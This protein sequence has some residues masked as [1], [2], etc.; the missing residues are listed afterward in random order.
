[1]PDDIQEITLRPTRVS[2]AS[3][4]NQPGPANF[5]AGTEATL[6]PV[7]ITQNMP[8]QILEQQAATEA[9]YKEMAAP[10][11]PPPA[12]P[13]LSTEAAPLSPPQ[14]VPPPAEPP[15][16]ALTPG[17]TPPPGPVEPAPQISE[18]EHR[19]RS[20][21]G[22]ARAATI[23][24]EAAEA[25]LADLT[26]RLTRL[27]NQR[28]QPVADGPLPDLTPEE[29]ETMGPEIVAMVN[30]RAAIIARGETERLRGEIEALRAGQQ[31]IQKSAQVSARDNMLAEL[32]RVIPNWQTTNTDDKFI[33]WLSQYDRLR[34]K[35]R[36]DMLLD[37]YNQNDAERVIA[38]FQEYGNA[39]GVPAQGA[40]TPQPGAV[41]PAPNKLP[42][43]S[44]AA[45]ARGA[46]SAAPSETEKHIW[47]PALVTAFYRDVQNGR[48][49][50]K[51]PERLM[52]EA[53]LINAQREGRYKEK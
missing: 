13:P 33:N 10:P 12:D 3:T 22:R 28:G 20:E 15:P 5:A 21:Q 43:E 11:A 51:E 49:A 7:K 23:R 32:N 37:A 27:E 42:L 18:W 19:Y 39:S 14:P 52:W 41:P 53:D 38:F 8:R 46:S 26:T 36:Q 45:P 25:Q 4:P 40:S 2:R 1:M 34:G 44:F 24:A 35:T 29:M 47:T 16:T 48:F 17:V 50:G 6:P 31:S 30:K 9:L